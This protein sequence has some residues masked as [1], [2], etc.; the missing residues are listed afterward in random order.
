MIH[1]I[2]K[3]YLI[4]KIILG[5]V[6]LGLNIIGVYYLQIVGLA[7]SMNVASLIYLVM[8]IMINRKVK[9]NLL[10]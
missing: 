5:V 7:I 10:K 2:P 9:N 3:I 6:S 1:E 4:P 8:V